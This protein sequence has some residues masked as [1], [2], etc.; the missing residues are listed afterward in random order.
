MNVSFLFQVDENL[1]IVALN[2]QNSDVSQENKLDL[3]AQS[4]CQTLGYIDIDSQREVFEKIQKN[5]FYES[6]LCKTGG[7]WKLSEPIMLK[8]SDDAFSNLPHICTCCTCIIQPSSGPSE[9][10]FSVAVDPDT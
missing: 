5:D 4:E 10:A 1:T 9:C 2:T 3:E 7:A 6:R 8:K